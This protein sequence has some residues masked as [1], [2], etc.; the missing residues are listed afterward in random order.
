MGCHRHRWGFHRCRCR[1]P[2]CLGFRHRRYLQDLGFRFAVVAVGRSVVPVGLVDRFGFDPVAAGSD[3]FGSVRFGFQLAG[4]LV[5]HLAVH[6]V[7]ADLVHCLAVDLA[8]LAD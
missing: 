2:G 4:R 7:A 8:D 5:D 6:L 3:R 1:Y